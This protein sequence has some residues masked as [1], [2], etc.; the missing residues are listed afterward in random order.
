MARSFVRDCP[1]PAEQRLPGAEDGP[2]DYAT[3]QRGEG[4]GHATR[5]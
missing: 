2:G 1:A 3:E 5:A 4:V